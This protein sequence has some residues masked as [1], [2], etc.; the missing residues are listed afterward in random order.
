MI[1]PLFFL[2][3]FSCKLSCSLPLVILR[4]C[5]FMCNL[6]L[7]H[8]YLLCT[9]R[10]CSLKVSSAQYPLP[11]TPLLS[12]YLVLGDTF[13]IAFCV[14]R[15]YICPFSEVFGWSFKDETKLCP[16]VLV[17]SKNCSSVISGWLNNVTPWTTK[18]E[19][20]QG[21]NSHLHFAYFD[22]LFFI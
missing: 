15:D 1:S 4:N 9:D 7:K 16:E 5:Q 18:N 14:L 12:L 20:V 17:T 10:S 6:T 13:L 11:L 8:L 22:H 19:T 2:A 3:S 21:H